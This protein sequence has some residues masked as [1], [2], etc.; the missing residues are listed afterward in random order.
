MQRVPRFTSALLW[1]LADPERRDAQ[2]GDL[3]E[4]FGS[5]A[6]RSPHDARRWYRRQVLRSIAPNVAHRCRRSW[7][8][9]TRRGGDGM[10]GRLFHDFRLSLRAA[11]RNL[12]F[13]SVI[14]LTLALGIGANTTIFS[15]V[16][17]LVLDPFP[18]PEPD[19]IVGIGTAYPKLS[20]PLS[21]FEN[22][23]PAEFN[24]LRENSGSL[25][26]VVAWDM[27]N[28][29][30]DTDGTPENVFSAFWWGDPLTTLGMP[31]YLGRGFS[32]DELAS[33]AAVVMIGEDMWRSRF[34]ADSAMVGQA[35]SVNGS[36]Y[37]LLGVFPAGV[38]LYGTDLWMTMPVGPEV[39]PRN[40]RQFQVMGRIREGRSLAEVNAE[41]Q[42]LARRTEQEYGA[43][44][45]EYQGWRM[46]AMTWSNVSSQ[47]F[48]TGVLV[49]LGA[50][51][52]VLLLVCANTA[53]LL[54][55][56]AQGRQREMAV[57]VAMGAGR[58]RLFGQLLTE[59]VTLAI[60]GGALGVGLAYAGVAGVTT[61]LTT[62]GLSVA[63]TVAL[64]GPVMAFTAVVAVAAGVLF[65]LAPA[66]QTSRVGIAGALQ[67]DGKGATAGA[68]RQR[69]QHSLVAVEVALAF[70]LLTG[71]GLLVHSLVRVTRVDPG[72]EVERLLTMRLTL[73]PQKY[74][75]AEVPAFFRSLA[76]R[77]ERVPGV[78]QASAGTQFPSVAFSF[79]Q[80]YFDGAE[81][82]AEATLPTTLATVVRPGYFE[83]LGVPLLRGRTFHD[84]D[85][86]D[87]PWV[88]VISEETAER[89]FP[90]VDPLGRRLKVGSSDDQT[91]WWESVGVVGSTR[92]LG[93]A[94]DPFPEIFAVHEQVGAGQN[95]LFMIL[96]TSVDPE[97][98]VPA[99][100]GA[101]A[102]LDP[103][104]PIYAI[105]TIEEAYRQGVAPM[106]ATTLLLAIFAVF[107]LILAAVGIYSVVSFTVSGRTQEIGVRVA[108]G[109]NPTRVRGLVVRQSLLPVVIGAFGGLVASVAVSGALQ[110]MLFEIDGTDPLT[111]ASVAAILVLVASAASWMPA[112]RASRMDPVE[113]LRAE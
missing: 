9:L 18:F 68:G 24:D 6:D 72:F 12:A 110:R 4:E 45:D 112:F 52:F 69:L 70:V 57:R 50:V 111:L 91:P 41:L 82:D 74:Q 113:A 47:F 97:S 103:D 26:E 46:Q 105:R 80:I 86:A 78:E 39:F 76:E 27:G 81:A 87:A 20:S 15:V 84:G 51:G 48:R 43:E 100:R 83:A 19:R 36:P 93:L 54:L 38:D 62:I 104:Q 33:G 32:D 29:Q 58:G 99:V 53:N 25:E 42:G 7:K 13:S 5:R 92:T 1:L 64:N 85:V 61:F 63:G 11:R 10:M 40:G 95:Q 75:D 3:A 65:G 71:G 56:R 98:V 90:G 102:E 89:Y 8:G 2:L 79:R 22:L 55:A 67:S 94:Q 49:L 30:I 77:L 60:L 17:G 96:R 31:A 106:R 109:A 16:Y 35:I 107:G 37:T 101:V 66:F 44:F 28:R 108:L 14:V 23:S 73:P 59:S 34:G 21:F 88:A